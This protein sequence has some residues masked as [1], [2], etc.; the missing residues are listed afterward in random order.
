MTGQIEEYWYLLAGTWYLVPGWDP[1]NPPPPALLDME[2]FLDEVQSKEKPPFKFAQYTK[3]RANT[4]QRKVRQLKIEWQ[5]PRHL[6]RNTLTHHFE[7]R[8]RVKL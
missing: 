8:T 7:T 3:S 6:D 2:G 5:V 1:K 4:S